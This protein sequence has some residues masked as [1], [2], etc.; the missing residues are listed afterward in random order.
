MDKEG[1]GEG[2]EAAA[3]T[4]ELLWGV[5]KRPGRGPKRGL[6]VEKVVEAA[7]GIADEEG[8]EA[9][10]M[11]RVADRL[12]VGV[13]SLYTYVPGKAELTE[14]ML[15]AALGEAEIPDGAGGGWRAGLELY[16]R[17]SW[18][19]SHRH[20]WMLQ[21]LSSGRGL[22]GPNQTAM[23]DSA[24]HAVSGLGLT[25]REMVSL[26]FVVVGYVRGAA[27]TAVEG[28][29]T[30]QATG[31]TDEQWWSSYGRLVA[32]YTAD[33]ERYPTLASLSSSAWTFDRPEADFEFGL[34]RVLDGIEAF[35]RGRAAHLDQQ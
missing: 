5:R 31:V 15:D 21:L 14:L 4:L 7:V 30:E 32:E 8:L 33:A 11:R 6:S 1:S 26:F 10:S 18:R 29:H 34:Q 25:D 22:L 2:I 35:I 3:R 17:E 24:L 19:L 28:T 9:L 23:L 27:Q 20:P 12:G 16:A 13:M